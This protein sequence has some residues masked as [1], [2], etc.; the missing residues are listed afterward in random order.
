METEVVRVEIRSTHVE[1]EVV[2][3]EIRSTHVETE[4][5]KSGNKKYS[6]G[7]RDS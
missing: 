1:T 2:R 7:N 5:V 4:V 6:C 3:V